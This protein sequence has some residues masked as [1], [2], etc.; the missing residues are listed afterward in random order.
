VVARRQ[1]LEMGMG[2]RAIACR[3]GR[4]ALHPVH[5]GVYAVGRTGLSRKGQWMAAV[6]CGGR[7]AVLSHR[8]AGKIWKLLTG[9]VGPLEI[10]RPAGLRSRRTGIVGHQANLS[11]D[12]IKFPEGIPVTSPFRTVFD[13]AAVLSKRQLERAMNEADVLRLVDRVSLPQL[14]DRHPGHRGAANLRT[15]LAL[16]DPGGITR[17]EFEEAFVAL[18][19][20]HGLPR[21]RLNADLTIRGRFFEIDCL[22]Q[23]QRVVVELDGRAV[24][25]TRRAFEADRERDRIL[26]VEGW[27]PLRVTW[28]QLH[29]EPNSIVGDLRNLLGD[30]SVV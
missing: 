19:D 2:R 27:R 11:A 7:G 25:G 24:H 1:L 5:R 28:R 26:L 14:L 13:L 29:D 16:N 3:L 17:N 21:P 20:A 23:A 6:L 9:G 30:R 18:L 4:G 10:T 12:E 8:P 15:L 22:W